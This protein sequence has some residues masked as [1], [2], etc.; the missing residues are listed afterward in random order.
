MN[1]Y[2]KR[3]VKSVLFALSVGGVV[4][5][6]GRIGNFPFGFSPGG[7]IKASEMTAN[8]DAV[9]VAVNDSQDKIDALTSKISALEA[10]Q[11][12]RGTCPGTT[13]KVGDQCVEKTLR[14]EQKW[15]QAGESCV[16]AAGHLCPIATL[17]VACKS[18]SLEPSF[19]GFS[20]E[21]SSSETVRRDVNTDITAG[22]VIAGGGNEK[23]NVG[24]FLNQQ[25]AYSYR[26]C[27]NPL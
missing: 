16:I 25:S 26:C 8:F 5:L 17:Y 6:G 4:A 9:K 11:A 3:S 1:V 7:P 23:C 27:F 12:L 15:Q 20:A 22:G 19:S 21:W 24:G 18:P 10:A 13:V 2:A 14:P